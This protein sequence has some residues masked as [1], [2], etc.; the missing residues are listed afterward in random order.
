MSKW[1]FLV[2]VK[3]DMLF[4]IK[5]IVGGDLKTFTDETAPKWLCEGGVKG[6][7]MDNRWFWNDYVLTLGINK[8]VKTDFSIIRRL[9]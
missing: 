9:E 4:S 1:Q 3:I 8:T 6:S 7:T 2:Q 5:S